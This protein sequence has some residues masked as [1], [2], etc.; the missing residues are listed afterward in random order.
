MLVK[1]QEYVHKILID[2]EK[3]DIYTSKS[4]TAFLVYFHIFATVV[5]VL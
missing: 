2:I 1:K 4:N 5:Y 3:R